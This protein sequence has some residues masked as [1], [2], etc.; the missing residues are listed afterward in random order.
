LDIIIVSIHNSL[1]TFIHKLPKRTDIRKI[2]YPEIFGEL[3]IIFK[4]LVDVLARVVLAYMY[5]NYQMQKL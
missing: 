1:L 2:F 5:S 4:Y 3:V